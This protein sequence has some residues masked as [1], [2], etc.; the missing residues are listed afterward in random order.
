MAASVKR[1]QKQDERTGGIV[2]FPHRDYFAI[3]QNSAL[4]ELER[5]IASPSRPQGVRAKVCYA[6]VAVKLLIIERG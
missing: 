2:L 4:K 3:F 1:D 6:G 5:R